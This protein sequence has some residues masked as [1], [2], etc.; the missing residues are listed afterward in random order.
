MSRISLSLL[1][2]AGVFAV[3]LP[4]MTLANARQP[5]PEIII[6]LD[7][8][9][10]KLFRAGQE[11]AKFPV[12][13][14]KF[15]VG[16]EFHSYKTPTGVFEVC[17]KTGGNLPLGAVIKRGKPT[18]EVLQPDAPGRDPIVTRMIRL[19][20]LEPQ[21]RHA[22]V[23]GIFIHGTPEERRLG[24]PVSWGCI[25]MRSKDVAELYRQVPVGARVV[26]RGSG[27][28]SGPLGWLARIFA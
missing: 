15:G 24:K 18:G 4:R 5:A 9:E 6:D 12:S 21:N 14:S 1:F 27:R 17:D 23:R 20:G 8:Q 25:R 22:L 11:V 28:P 2:W 7:E 10:M 3:A 19:R 26:I 13:T 16:D